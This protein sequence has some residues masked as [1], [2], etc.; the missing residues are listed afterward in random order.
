M[1]CP[2]PAV[3]MVRLSATKILVG[4]PG[5]KVSTEP[6]IIISWHFSRSLLKRDREINMISYTL[7]LKYM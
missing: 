4:I 5:R 2:G 6:E 3:S 1:E 7:T